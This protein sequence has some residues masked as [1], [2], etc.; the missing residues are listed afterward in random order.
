MF[1]PFR[2]VFLTL[3]FPFFLTFLSLLSCAPHICPWDSMSSWFPPK[4]SVL[5]SSTLP[6]LIPAR[7]FVIFSYSGLLCYGWQPLFFG[8]VLSLFRQFNF[9]TSLTASRR[10]ITSSAL[11]SKLNSSY[12]SRVAFEGYHL[13]HRGDWYQ[14]MFDLSY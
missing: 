12:L 8:K 10:Y 9:I 4:T 6:H 11:K 14:L 13:D 5:L 1:S 7:P 2:L 3:A